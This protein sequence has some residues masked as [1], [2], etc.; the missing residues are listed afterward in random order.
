MATAFERILSRLP[1]TAERK[2]CLAFLGTQK[3][4]L[5]GGD[6]LAPF[7][8]GVPVKVG[9][10]PDPAQ[11]AREDLVQVLF[12]HNDFVMIR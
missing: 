9:P 5:S 7:A 11:R 10:S 3:Q 6:K 1:T 2:E 8:G 4:L 12:N